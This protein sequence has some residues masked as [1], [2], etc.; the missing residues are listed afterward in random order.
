[1][2][3]CKCTNSA[4]NHKSPCGTEAEPNAALCKDCREKN[5]A[6]AMGTIGHDQGTPPTRK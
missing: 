2:A 4:H 5:A 3:T 6:K 1:M